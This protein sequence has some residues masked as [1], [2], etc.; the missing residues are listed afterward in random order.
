MILSQKGRLEKLKEFQY[1]YKLGLRNR[2]DVF[3][4]IQIAE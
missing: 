4:L 1:V 2:K 3:G